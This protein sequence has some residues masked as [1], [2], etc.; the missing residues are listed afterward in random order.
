MFWV[1]NMMAFR[2]DAQTL[3]MVVASEE[4]GILL[5]A[6]LDL[7]DLPRGDTD[8]SGWT[9]ANTS[10]NDISKVDLLN[11]VGRKTGL[12]DSV[13]DSSDTELRSGQA[14]EGSTERSDRG[15]GSRKD[16]DWV[17]FE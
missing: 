10:R 13:L 7:V 2:P 5:S 1:A 14:R 11:L 12:F 3:L 15:S 17:F 4:L 16:V 9:L 8:L 6:L